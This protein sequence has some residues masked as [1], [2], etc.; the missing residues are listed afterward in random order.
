[1]T[2]KLLA[3]LIKQHKQEVVKRHDK[4][5][6]LYESDHEILHQEKKAEYKP[7]NR[8][9][10]NFAKYNV[11]TFN[12][13]FM[14]IPV[15]V[16]HDDEKISDYLEYLDKYNGLDDHHSELS[17]MCDIYGKGYELLFMDEQSNVGIT[18]SEVA[19]T[20][21]IYDESILRRPMYGV[22]YYKDTD[23]VERGSFSSTSTITY[24]KS[25]DTGYVFED[26]KAHYFG[27]VP[28]IEY[29]ENKERHGLCD[30]VE[31]LIN[32]HNKALSEKANDVDY[33][34]DAYLKILGASFED[35]E[36]QKLKEN[37]TINLEG[38]GASDIVVDFLQRPS[39][40]ETQEHLIERLEKLIFQLS[41]VANI[42]DENFGTS[43]G[44]AMKYKLQ[45]MSNL[46]ASKERKFTAGMNKR[47]KMIANVPI[48]KL[49]ADDWIGIEYTFTRNVPNNLAEEAE[50]AG[51]LS[52]IVSKKT[53]LSILSVVDNAAA[54]ME[55]IKE[56]QEDANGGEFD[57]LGV[58]ED[59]EQEE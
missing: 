38:N 51:K 2:P 59:G 18:T 32:A 55:R 56:E 58:E 50:T 17:K 4:Q 25:G 7:D 49:K 11:D 13:Y 21:V 16:K 37:R 9:V 15:K 40:D 14:G 12:G 54:E 45:S 41:M 34:A 36:I 30:D 3:E 52:G 26:A 10:A 22:R 43:S 44:I 53:Q 28:I 47:Y 19:E 39:S 5:K 27:D 33:F 24:F 29:V 35:K 23:S 31:T 6:K 20:F 57:R 48:S 1:M 46:A 42:N 8:L